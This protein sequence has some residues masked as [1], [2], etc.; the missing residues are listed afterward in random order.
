MIRTLV[1]LLL[2]GFAHAGPEESAVRVRHFAGGSIGSGSGTVV[3]SDKG[4][5]LVLTNQHVA[6][7]PGQRIAVEVGDKAYPATWLAADEGID[8]AVLRVDAALPA[9]EL[10]DAEPAP[11]TRL[12]QWGHPGGG[13]QKP[14]AGPAFGFEGS[15]RVVHGRPAG[16]VFSVGIRPESGDSGCGVFDPSGKLVAVCWG[17]GGSPRQSCVRLHDI[18]QFLSRVK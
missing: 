9:V 14:K 3:R 10:A 17:G 18:R 12:R 11:G 15:R 5:S 8:L 2:A 13:P 16:E 6:P 7:S 1:L 4:G